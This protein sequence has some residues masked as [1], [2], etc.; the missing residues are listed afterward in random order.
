MLFLP[1]YLI[2][3]F[4]RIFLIALLTGC[5]TAPVPKEIAYSREAIRA[6]YDLEPWSLDGRLAL[7]GAND[8]WQADINWEHL[9]GIDQIKLSGP[10]GQGA[11]AI[12]L[13]KDFVTVARGDNELKSSGQPEQFINQQLGLFVPVRSLRYWVVGLPMPDRT[14]EDI[15]G[16]FKQDGW[17]V[18]YPQMQMVYGKLMP[19]KIIVSGEQVKLKLII[20]QWIINGNEDQ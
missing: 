3:F 15:V 19:R 4:I 20:D 11:V 14:F 17:Q 7:T 10:L 5:A 2:R 6:L 13:T 16:G 12:H 18:D 1:D 8:S 9:T